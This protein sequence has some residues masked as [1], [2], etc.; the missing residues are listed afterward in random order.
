MDSSTSFGE[1]LIPFTRASASEGVLASHPQS[2]SALGTGLATVGVCAAV[3]PDCSNK[4]GPGCPLPQTAAVRTTTIENRLFIY[5]LQSSFSF[6]THLLSILM[7]VGVQL[8]TE[9]YCGCLSLKIDR[10]L[11]QGPVASEYTFA[12]VLT[13][14]AT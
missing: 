3:D 7:A 14:C 5:F 11:I 1:I 6:A 9:A 13:I 4:R 2:S 12:S 10:N 8:S